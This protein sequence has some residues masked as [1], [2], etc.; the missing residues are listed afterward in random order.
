MEPACHSSTNAGTLGPRR[1]GRYDQKFDSVLRDKPTNGTVHKKSGKGARRGASEERSRATMSDV[2]RLKRFFMYLFEEKVTIYCHLE[3]GGYLPN[4]C[5][6]AAR[7]RVM[8]A[9]RSRFISC[10]H[11]CASDMDS[12]RGLQ[13]DQCSSG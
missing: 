8:Q 12:P 4:W 6:G 1:E 10:A 3:A 7:M 13:A 2:G 9:T 5:S 11:L